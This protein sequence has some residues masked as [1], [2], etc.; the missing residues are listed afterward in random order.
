MTQKTKEED[1]YRILG[2]LFVGTEVDGKSG[3]ISLMRAKSSYYEKTVEPAIKEAVRK[4]AEEEFKFPMFREDMFSHL[5]EFFKRYFCESGSVYF[6]HVRRSQEIYQRV[7]A[8]DKDLELAWKTQGM[9]YVKSDYLI[10]SMA[11]E[12]KDG[13]AVIPMWFDASDMEKRANNERRNF[14]FEY[15]EAKT[16]VDGKKTMCFKVAFSK[17]G[18]VTKYADIVKAAHKNGW[19]ELT[20]DMLEAACR[21]FRRQTEVDYFIRRDTK[22]FLQEQWKFFVISQ[23]GSSEE[24]LDESRLR[25]IYKWQEVARCVI[26]FIAQ[27]EDENKRV[28]EKPKFA[29]KV[30]YVVT[31][32]RLN[33]ETLQKVA[34]HKGAKAQMD[35]WKAAGMMNGDIAE[36]TDVVQALKQNASK[37]SNGKVQY[38]PLDTAH[39]KDLEYD[40][41][42]CLGDLDTALDGELVK[43]E[44]WQA[45]NTL[46]AKY[47]GRVKC[48]YIDP[49]FNL[50]GS[51]QFDYRTNYKD[52][53]WATMLQNRLELGRDFLSKDGGI[54]VRC[55]YNGN[56]IVRCLLDEIFGAKNFKNEIALSRGGTPKGEFTKM[57]TGYDTTYLYARE[58]SPCAFSAPLIKRETREWQEMHLPS[59]RNT[60]D[61]RCRLFN[62]KKCYPPQGRH[63]ALSQSAI[64]ERLKLDTVRINPDREYTNTEGEKV[65]GMPESLQSEYQRK[66]ANWTDIQGYS[67]TWDFSTENSEVL[68]K[69]CIDSLSEAGDICMDFFSGSG[70]TMAVAQK[71]GRKWL[72]MEM[73]DHFDS[74]ILPRLK[75][76]LFGHQSGISKEVEYKGGGAFVYYALEQYEETLGKM[77]YDDRVLITASGGKPFEEYLFL[78]DE[79]LTGVLKAEKGGKFKL[80]LQE[81]YGDISLPETLANALGVPLRRKNGKQAEFADGRVL[82]I[83]FASMSSEEH[84][85]IARIIAPYLWWGT[86]Q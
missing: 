39:F 84:L 71:L 72:G 40:I 12:A 82:K 55:D 11:V 64:D 52:S 50:D 3:F 8:E 74:V 27:F 85:E 76:V 42:E 68:L 80:K 53:C 77:Q 81:L 10:Q 61:L 21:S 86:E 35:E 44:N 32:D 13:N 49:P 45:L 60:D 15:D 2:E 16:T 65:S 47:H 7:Y 70:T 73:G 29:R 63:W 25:Q 56:W 37:K 57:E 66:D 67:K 22:T 26:M 41:L 34:Q 36:F 59:E 75:K 24:G 18:R 20:V 28:W 83:D 1:F 6:R 30:N 38:L 4:A 14:V 17:N 51:D 78:T 69:R 43:S 33:P 31:L 54:F 5:H 46:R 79:K 9:Y 62:G 48:V 19:K 23:A 58:F